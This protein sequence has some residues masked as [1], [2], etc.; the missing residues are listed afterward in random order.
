MVTISLNQAAFLEKALQ[1]VVEQ[2]Y[3]NL[4][5][6]VID[7]GSTDGSVDIIRKYERHLTYWVSEPDRGQSHA[8]NK[9]LSR[10]TG[11]LMG[12]LNSDDHFL[13]GAFDRFAAAWR[14]HPEAGAWVGD[15]AFTDPGGRV[16][17]VK[18]P[19]KLDASCLADWGAN[20]FSQPACLF[21]R[22]AWQRCGPIDETLYI[23][24]D[25]DLWLKIA[26]A[27]P[28]ERIPATMAA[29]T[30]HSSAKTQAYKGRM[31]I[32][33]WM[34]QMRHGFHDMAEKDMMDTLAQMAEAEK[35]IERLTRL[36]LYR[37]FRPLVRLVLKH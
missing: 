1:S 29:A 4:E 31:R 25:F 10:C 5:Y 8:L 30:I 11:E 3:P 7:G 15:A 35:K 32:E 12:W 2:G 18:S 6:I 26:M 37:L 16:I 28:F 17:R 27:F 9:G 20:G 13:P 33:T 22:A 34:V 19:G 21:S 23:A 24:M 36:P 14:E